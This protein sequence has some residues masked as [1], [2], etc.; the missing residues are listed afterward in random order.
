MGIIADVDLLADDGGEFISITVLAYPIG[1]SL[2]HIQ[3]FQHSGA[4]K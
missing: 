4:M 2:G 1:M 3:C